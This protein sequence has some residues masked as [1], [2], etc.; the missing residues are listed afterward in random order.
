MRVYAGR[1]NAPAGRGGSRDAIWAAAAELFA[2][3]GYAGTSVRDIGAAAGVDAALVIRY[4][5]SKENL[6]LD[7]MRLRLP[8]PLL[9]G[10]IST[11][12]ERFIREVL[13]SDEHVKRVFLALLRASDAGEVDTR[14]REAHEQHFVAPLLERLSGPDAELRARLAAALVGGL[15]YALWVVGDDR[16]AAEPELIVRQYG[17]LLQALITP[18]R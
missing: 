3:T 5:G 4:F 6:F 9:A 13:A 7:T 14:L 12:G 8:Q 1:V 10:D 16:L 11:L 18:G 17:A 2:R 15:L